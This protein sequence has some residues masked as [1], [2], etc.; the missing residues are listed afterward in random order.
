[1]PGAEW[2]WEAYQI[3]SERRRVTEQ[4]PDPIQIS[5]IAAYADFRGITAEYE[6]ELLLEVL[7]ALD[8]AFM[9]FV[10]KKTKKGKPTRPPRK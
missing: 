4:G 8:N 5:E 3:L 9:T 1:M 10:R 7:C 6:R 2:L